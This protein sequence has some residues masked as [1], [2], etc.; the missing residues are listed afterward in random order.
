MSDPLIPGLMRVPI[1]LGTADNPRN[2]FFYL[3]NLDQ[4]TEA[5]VAGTPSLEPDT[6][7]GTRVFWSDFEITKLVHN[8]TPTAAADLPDDEQDRLTQ[9]TLNFI[10]DEQD[11]NAF[12]IEFSR[13]EVDGERGWA[14]RVIDPETGEDLGHTVLHIRESKVRNKYLQKRYLDLCAHRTYRAL[15]TDAFFFSKLRAFEKK[16]LKPAEARQDELEETIAPIRQACIAV[17]HAHL[18]VTAMIDVASSP[19]RRRKLWNADKPKEPPEAFDPLIPRSPNKIERQNAAA[20]RDA[21]LPALFE[22]LSKTLA[23]MNQGFPDPEGDPFVDA[24]LRNNRAQDLLDAL[25]SNEHI[26]SILE[27]YQFVDSYLWNRMEGILLRAF[28]ILIT[29][30]NTRQQLVKGELREIA[31]HVSRVP[32]QLD[33]VTVHTERVQAVLDAMARFVP[34]TELAG[35]D[36]TRLSEAILGIKSEFDPV[37][38]HRSTLAKL[39]AMSVPTMLE[40]IENAAR[41]RGDLDPSAVAASWGWRASFNIADLKDVSQKELIEK[42]DELAAKPSKKK[43]KAL[44]LQDKFVVESRAGFTKVGWASF[45]T[46]VAI[47]AAT[48]AF[49]ENSRS[50]S[51]RHSL[52]AWTAALE[53]VKGLPDL[54]AAISTTKPLAQASA[55]IGKSIFATIGALSDS[56]PAKILDGF[57]GVLKYAAVVDATNTTLRSRKKTAEDK[58]AAR[59]KLAVAG[60]S[61]ALTA[62]GLTFGAPVVIA[63]SVLAAGASVLLSRKLWG[64][65]L[66]GYENLPG[67]GRA[68][69]AAFDSLVVDSAR[70]EGKGVDP[71]DE[72]PGKLTL[73]F[74]LRGSPWEQEITNTLHSLESV[75]SPSTKVGL[76]CFW[77]VSSGNVIMTNFVGG[78]ISRQ[79]GL[80]LGFAKEVAKF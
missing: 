10:H 6:S 41:K 43:A 54:A 33:A 3:I 66:A 21:Q 20:V 55:G 80:D 70:N 46:A 38:D 24:E 71:R 73:L 34:P 15:H 51:P 49:I 8:L 58:D 18:A 77:P 53:A 1:N 4:L 72:S 57:V 60:V 61:L 44:F 2:V 69:R 48:D 23:W 67:P 9:N 11:L 45:E 50:P 75:T 12:A 42:V 13:T 63:G 36:P 78:I 74:Q 28:R 26:I 19:D 31:R 65:T 39:W 52:E 64:G 17:S 79:Y 22:H 16:H 7:V 29:A 68:V 47:L 25:R 76:G 37:L 40:D 35:E 14:N 62:V 59:E 5:V 32:P 27:N 30:P 56:P